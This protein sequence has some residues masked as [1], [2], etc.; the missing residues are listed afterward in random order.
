MEVE[1]I[2][3]GGSRKQELGNWIEEIGKR[4]NFKVSLFDIPFN[5]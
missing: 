2:E 5:M 4:R 3:D 1:N